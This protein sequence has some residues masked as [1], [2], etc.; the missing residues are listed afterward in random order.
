MRGMTW[1]CDRAVELLRSV[2]PADLQ[3]LLDRA[4][5]IAGERGSEKLGFRHLV[6]AA[7]I[8]WRKVGADAPT[9]AGSGRRG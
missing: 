4:E 6:M 9:D 8:P 2:D 1:T 5:V 3:A 7:D